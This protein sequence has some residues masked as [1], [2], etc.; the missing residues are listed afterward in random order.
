MTRPRHHS[1]QTKLLEQ[2]CQWRLLSLLLSRPIV[3]RKREARRLAGERMTRRLAGA[4]RTWC[5]NAIEGDYLRLLGPG[6]LVPAR[7]VAYRPFADPGWL[8]ADIARYHHA[9]GFRP[10]AEE[11]PD[12]IAVL[13]DFVAYLLFKEAYARDRADGDAAH[14]TYAARERFIEEHMAPVARPLAERLD[15][16][17]ATGWSAAARLLAEKVPPPPAPVTLGEREEEA[18]QCGGCPAGPA[19]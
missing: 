12:H 6:G 2:A 5:D 17:G 14:V 13:A 11:P 18:P 7:A 1:S 4:A 19:I 8:L 10:T 9:F 16:C 15:A 3:Q